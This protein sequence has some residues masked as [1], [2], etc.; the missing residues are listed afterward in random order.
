MNPKTL[1]YYDKTLLGY[2]KPQST[3]CR[4]PLTHPTVRVIQE[5]NMQRLNASECK[6]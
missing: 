2:I 3:P 5:E 4:R 6:P 1:K